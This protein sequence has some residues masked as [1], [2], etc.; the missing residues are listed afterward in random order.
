MNF[1]TVENSTKE[2]LKDFGFEFDPR[3]MYYYKPIQGGHQVVFFHHHFY[4]DASYMEY[5]VGVRLDEVENLVHKFLPS[6]TDYKNRSLTVIASLDM[7]DPN[8]PKRFL[9]ESEEEAGSLIKDVESFFISKGFQWLDKFS[10]PKNLEEW[11]NQDTKSKIP[12]QNFTYRSFRGIVLSKLYNPARYE[13][14]KKTY[15]GLLHKSG[16]TPFTLA[17]FIN[18]LNELEGK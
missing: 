12:T 2:F 14:T 5:Q 1:K 3:S 7:I 15:L 16:V 10:Q 13:E 18:L 4:E 9:I 6:V 8:L 17:C 11:F